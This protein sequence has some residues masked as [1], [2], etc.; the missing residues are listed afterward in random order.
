MLRRSIRFLD[1]IGI[2]AALVGSVGVVYFL[3]TSPIAFQKS[4]SLSDA[5]I[6]DPDWTTAHAIDARKVIGSIPYHGSEAL[7][8]VLPRKLYER[9]IL[10]GYGNCA[11]KTRGL[12]YFLL[13]EGIPFERVDLI[14]AD[15]FMQ[16]RGHTLVRTKYVLDGVTRVGMIDILEGGVPALDRVPIDLPQLRESIPYT[17]KLLPLNVLVD[18]HS[19]YYGSF[20]ETANIG[21]VDHRE[22]ARYF[23]FVETI[24]VSLNDARLERFI[25]NASAVVLGIFPQLHVSPTEFARLKAQSPGTFALAHALTWSARGF[26]VVVVLTMSLRFVQFLRGLLWAPRTQGAPIAAKPVA[27]TNGS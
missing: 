10:E 11:N 2:A 12:S 5:P 21:V 1:F 20:L 27:W 8:D 3:S 6:I 9:T 25:C 22:I 14:P 16:G 19:D 4:M 15:G 7:S 26:I 13:E 18:D 24:Y 17:L 23:R